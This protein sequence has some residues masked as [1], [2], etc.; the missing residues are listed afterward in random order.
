MKTAVEWLAD[1][2]CYIT[3]NGKYIVDNTDDV[4]DVVNQAKEMEKEQMVQS[5]ANGQAD[6]LSLIKNMKDIPAE[7]NKM[8]SDNFNDLV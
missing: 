3:D 8:I 2:L 5:Y 1:E 7:F 4:T 6:S